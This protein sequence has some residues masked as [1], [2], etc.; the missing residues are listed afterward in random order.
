MKAKTPCQYL[1]FVVLVAAFLSN[2][3]LRADTTNNLYLTTPGSSWSLEINVPGFDLE[4]REL[5]PDGNAARLMA[6]NK[7]DGIILSAFLEKA[8]RAGDAKQCRE[9]YWQMAQKSP[10]PKDDVKM[11][12]T[13]SIALVEYLVKQYHGVPVN[14]KNINAYL[15]QAGYW[16][17]VHIS[18]GDFKPA[19]EA[20]LRA[21]IR[22]IRINEH[23]APSARDCAAFGIF[24]YEQKQYA[25][26]IPY[27]QKAL[28]LDKANRVFSQT[29]WTDI[30]DELITACGYTG[31]LEQA[32]ELCESGIRKEPTYPLFYYNLACAYAEMGD[33]K[34][35]LENLRMAYRYQANVP[36]HK[37]LPD[38]R[39]DSS[40]ARYL[41]DPDFAK[42]IA[43]NTK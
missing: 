4:Q 9:Y 41:S 11:S 5:L 6:E 23:F 27:Y 3:V 28:A 12:E 32:K 1:V 13:G 22:G 35:A 17:D 42:L 21:I 10:L 24:F 15:S 29:A 16:M 34:Q 19:D 43:E 33:K 7:T 8:P 25:R 20:Q 36:S 39:T 26:A 40:F 38:P 2:D 18:K 30:M 14:Q 31:K 37:E